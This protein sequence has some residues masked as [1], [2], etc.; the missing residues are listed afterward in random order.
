M[1]NFDLAHTLARALSPGRAFFNPQRF[2]PCIAELD[3]DKLEDGRALQSLGRNAYPAL[4]M[5]THPDI[6][7]EIAM[8]V[9]KQL[10]PSRVDVG[11]E[12]AKLML[13]DLGRAK[14]TDDV[15]A[16]G[17][18]ELCAKLFDQPKDTLRTAIRYHSFMALEWSFEFKQA[19]DFIELNPTE[20]IQYISYGS[21]CDLLSACFQPRDS[22]RCIYIYL[23]RLVDLEIKTKEFR[24]VIHCALQHDH[25]DH[26]KQG[27]LKFV[28]Y[29]AKSEYEIA[30]E[31][32]WQLFHK[33]K[34]CNQIGNIEK[35]FAAMYVK[36]VNYGNLEEPENIALQPF[37]PTWF[38]GK[39]QLV[40]TLGEQLRADRENEDLWSA[41][42]KLTSAIQ[43]DYFRRE[44]FHDK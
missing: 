44:L 24:K 29:I 16:I 17:F 39:D 32:I 43:Y 30:N 37:G 34:R 11:L 31:L 21:H 23:C 6:R 15:F 18:W 5:V 35:L 2:V 27:C 41:F 4:M 26:T 3:L 38:T 28:D 25:Y 36:M 12:L 13:C 19:D 14:T 22:N 7:A 40:N 8:T 9:F 20:P 33:T 10:A 1:L 42:E